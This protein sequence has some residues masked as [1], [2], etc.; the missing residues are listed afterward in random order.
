MKNVEIYMKITKELKKFGITAKQKL[1]IEEKIKLAQIAANILSENIKEL[2]NAYNELY[3]RIFNCDI[4]YATIE[5]KFCGVFYY[6]KNN[7]IYIDEKKDITNPDNY[8]IHEIIHYIQNFDKINKKKKIVGLCEFDDFKIIGLGIN[9]AIVQYIAS[10]AIGNKEVHKIKNDYIE[11]WTNSKEHYKYMT[12]LANQIL[13]L[14]GE[15][16][17]IK[18]CIYSTEDF[19]V[20]LYNTFEE[21][22]N[23]ILKG[24]DI[25]LEENDRNNRNEDKIIGTYMKVQKI[26]YTTYFLKIYNCLTTIKEV[27]VE[28]EKLQQ[29]EKIVGRL[30]ENSDQENEFKDFK[31]KM[32][33]KFLEKYIEVSRKKTKNSLTIYKKSISNLFNK[34]WIFIQSKIKKNKTS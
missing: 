11:I 9:E 13:L 31:M 8:I 20:E 25:I 21:N 29:Y 5:E 22:T 15:E 7:S 27:D 12:S 6:Y 10:K 4:Y 18:S 32:E 34:V 23:K 24:F 19:E 3:M 1:K 26:I 14:I 16:K 17:A 2:S 30:L 33:S 28:V